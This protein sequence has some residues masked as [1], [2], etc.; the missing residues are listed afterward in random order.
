MSLKFDA[1]IVG[2][3]R[4][5]REEIRMTLVLTRYLKFKLYSLGCRL[6]SG[7]NI[8][9]KIYPSVLE[10]TP[11]FIIFQ[12]VPTS[13]LSP[14][15][16]LLVLISILISITVP[17]FVFVKSRILSQKAEPEPIITLPRIQ[18]SIFTKNQ[19]SLPSWINIWNHIWNHI[20][21]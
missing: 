11:T 1:S 8:E 19:S 16:K 6:R 9:H 21:F 2:G 5:Q 20:W 7:R 4:E 12:W 14:Q 10:F 3:W 15:Q 17:I 18:E 13:L